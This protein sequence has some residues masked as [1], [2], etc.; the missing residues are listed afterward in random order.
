MNRKEL[1]RC[2]RFHSGSFIQETFRTEFSSDV[3]WNL[4]L[5]PFR[6]RLGAVSPAVSRRGC[7]PAMSLGE[8]DAA[9]RLARS[10]SQPGL[11]TFCSVA[12]LLSL[13]LVLAASPASAQIYHDPHRKTTIGFSVDL[14]ASPDTVTQIVKGVANDSVIR[15][16]FM[17]AKETEIEDADFAKTSSVLPHAPGSGQVFYKTKS[18]VISPAHFPAA[19]DIGTVTVRYVVEVVNPQRAHLTIDAVFVTDAGHR[20]Y[21]SDG[22][23]ET[24][25]YAEIMTQL[26]ALDAP[27]V[28]HHA[29]QT[30]AAAGQ[31][32]VGLQNTLADEQSQLADAKVTEQKL[33]ERIKQ[34]QFNTQGRIRGQAVPLKASPYD[35]AS[36]VL[37]LEKGL[38]VTVLTTTKYWYRVRT[39]KGDEGWLYYAF[40]EPLS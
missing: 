5:A 13:V 14:N 9:G 30:I 23:V 20:L 34:L 15:G 11:R 19:N 24:S 29:P 32:T 38:T 37:T 26:K 25:E 36:T 10:L 21:A 33:Q 7:V 40:L 31:E 22:S 28:R 39:S 1:R 4:Q 8:Y 17:Y 6:I 18:K 35:H 27:K 2:S 16:T 12:I 3:H